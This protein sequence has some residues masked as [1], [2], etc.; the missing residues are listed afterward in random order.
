[1]IEID[2]ALERFRTA[3]IE[4]GDLLTPAR[5]DH[6]LHTRM[7]EAVQELDAA[8]DDGRRAFRH[9]LHD[10]SPD[11]RAWVAAELLSRGDTAALV[12]MEDLARAEGVAGFN[13]TQV[14]REYRAGRLQSPF[15]DP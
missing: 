11:V 15:S 14:L 6:R 12:I 8:G 13:A 5:D 2:D 3:A 4:K 1:M 10:P 9:L 7:K